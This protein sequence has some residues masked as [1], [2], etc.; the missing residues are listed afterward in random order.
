MDRPEFV[1]IPPYKHLGGPVGAYLDFHIRYF[2]FLEQRSAVKVLKIAAMEKY[3]FQESSQPFRC[4]A[5]TCDAWFERPGEY[6]LHVIETKHDEGVTLPEPYESMFLANQQRLD[7]LH[8]FACAKIRAFK[9][10]WGE[11]G[12]EK[13]KTA[14][15]E[16]IDQLSRDP[17]YLQ[18]TPLEENWILQ[19]VKQVHWE[20]Y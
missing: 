8:K 18:D 19:E 2:G 14:E 13:R 5:S 3:H 20:H 17:L 16:L 9:E 1:I 7:E 10:W 12:S 4:P 11:S 15:K 6:T